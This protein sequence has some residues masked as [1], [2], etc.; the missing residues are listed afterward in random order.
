MSASQRG[1]RLRK[2]LN[3]PGLLFIVALFIIWEI[4]VKLGIVELVFLPAP[5]EIFSS[6]IEVLGSGQLVEDLLH[7]LSV[8]LLGWLIGAVLGIA[9]GTLLGVSP[10]VWRYSMATFD[11]LRSIP[12]ITFISVAALL[13][14]LS[15]QMELVVTVYAALWPILIN[16]V[17]G[18]RKIQPLYFETGKIMQMSRGK[19][20]TKIM[21]PAAAGSIIVGLRLGLGLALT[22]AVAAEMVG[23]PRGMGYQLIMQ[24][25][26]LNPAAM[27]VYILAIG[28]VGV[29]LNRMFLWTVA[30]VKPGIALSLRED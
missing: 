5:S 9:L 12:A 17:E 21:I 13:F 26:A 20:V 1:G 19:V 8:A 18:F 14:G 25:Q 22:L 2:I 28:L 7:T 11:L 30:I 23:N 27:F 6:F 29:V 16:T 15:R 4:V 24:Q 10:L 3:L